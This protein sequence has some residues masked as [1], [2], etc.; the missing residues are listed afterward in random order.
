MNH[1]CENTSLQKVSVE[2]LQCSLFPIVGHKN[3]TIIE[4]VSTTTTPRYDKGR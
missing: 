3:D 4:S 2:N 1:S